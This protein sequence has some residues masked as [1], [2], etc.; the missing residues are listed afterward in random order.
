MSLTGW[1]ASL[2]GAFITF[3]I[4]LSVTSDNGSTVSAFAQFASTALLGLLL[5]YIASQKDRRRLILTACAAFVLLLA[6]FFLYVWFQA[7]WTCKFANKHTVVI[8]SRLTAE[9][10]QYAK[11]NPH[12]GGCGQ[13]LGEFGGQSDAVY[14]KSDLTFRFI[15]LSVVYSLIWMLA[16]G[17]VVLVAVVSGPFLKQ[18][19]K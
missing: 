17:V 7:E 2:I 11:Q 6:S 14:V 3:P 5:A 12:L 9:A 13:L 16:A 1:L 8:G 15:V 4:A 10:G 19:R 18:R